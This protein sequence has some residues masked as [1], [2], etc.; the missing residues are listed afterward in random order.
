M[1]TIRGRIILGLL[2]FYPL[3]AYIT[4]QHLHNDPNYL[5]GIIIYALLG[6]LLLSKFRT[7]E[8]LR[9][10][11]YLVLLGAFTIYLFGVKIFVSD[12]VAKEGLIKYW[13]RDSFLRATAI[14]LIIENTKF[15]Q[16]AI[17]ISLKVLFWILICAAG[18]SIVQ[19]D[20]PLFFRNGGWLTG[21]FSTFK[22][23]ENYLGTLGPYFKDD[24]T[25]VL[26]G[27]RYSIYSWISGVS[28]GMDALA[29]FS[30][31]FAI[32]TLPKIKQY[33]LIISS[34]LI[35]ILSSSRWIM[36][37]FIAIFSQKVIGKKQPF[38]YGM[39]MVAILIVFG[40]LIALSASFMGI[41]LQ[42]FFKDR[43]M[44]DSANTR[45]YAFEVFG[46]VFPHHP[47][48]GTGGA[49]TQEMLDLIR[50]KTSQIHVGW[51]KL[52]YYYGLMGGILYILFLFMLLKHLYRRA[53]IS[54][55]WGSFF[56]F[57]AFTLANFT[58]VELNVFYHGLMLA[59][60]YS[61][62]LSNQEENISAESRPHTPIY[63]EEELAFSR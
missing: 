36:L 18:V 59:V 58:L 32:K 12:L 57:V 28:V 34:G 51:L 4:I 43:L 15:D 27:Y 50:G 42:H 46:K 17:N 9:L 54:N 19:I 2:C 3:Y 60:L 31:L 16:R 20:N 39:K 41:D 11:A 33:I 53:V 22:E 55:Y 35:S 1:D 61:R 40:A 5:S 24:I 37:N 13:Y 23:Y 30:I 21:G 7:D 56:A 63:R 8:T 49:D 52:F 26:E 45:F 25:P 14:L 44:N 48:F 38:I 10:P 29:I 6:E 47:I 62:Y